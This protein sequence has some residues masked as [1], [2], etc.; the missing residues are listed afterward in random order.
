MSDDNIAF[1]KKLNVNLIKSN[2]TTDIMSYSDLQEEIKN[3]FK[4]NNERYLEL[5]EVI[6]NRKQNNGAR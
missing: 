6:K 5:I 4:I 2:S 1:W 3:Y